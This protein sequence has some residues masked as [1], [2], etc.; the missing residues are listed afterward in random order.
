MLWPWKMPIVASP[1]AFRGG[2]GYRLETSV[3]RVG[4][5][6]ARVTTAQTIGLSTRIGSMPW[7]NSSAVYRVVKLISTVPCKLTGAAMN[8]SVR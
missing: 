1:H 4:I 8:E 2:R 3:P 5:L 6:R 7:T